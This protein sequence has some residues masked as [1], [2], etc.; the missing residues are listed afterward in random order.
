MRLPWTSPCRRGGASNV[1]PVYRNNQTRQHRQERRE[2]LKLRNAVLRGVRTWSGAFFDT[3]AFDRDRIV[4][5]PPR[6]PTALY[7]QS[8]ELVAMS[9]PLQLFLVYPV[10]YTRCVFINQFHTYW[11]NAHLTDNH[12]GRGHVKDNRYHGRVD[13]WN[14]IGRSHAMFWFGW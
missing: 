14:L 7:A 9:V 11:R 1:I 13:L 4:G 6:S 5:S 2:S 3:C 12:F 10:R 8:D